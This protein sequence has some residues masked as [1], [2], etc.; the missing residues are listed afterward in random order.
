MNRHYPLF[1]GKLPLPHHP[2]VIVLM[3]LFLSLVLIERSDSQDKQIRLRLERW[4]EVSQLS[5][6]VTYQRG[7]TVTPARKGMRLHT[8]GDT[9]QTGDRSSATL[10]LDTEVGSITVSANTTVRIQQLQRLPNGGQWTRLVVQGGQARFQ[11]RRMTV[12]NSRFEVETPAGST[13]VRGTEFGVSV[14]PNGR[15]GVTTQEGSVLVNAQNQ[16]YILDAGYSM[17]LTL[18]APPLA[19]ART[20]NETH[21]RLGILVAVDERTARVTGRVNPLN[22]IKIA[23]VPQTTDA[24]GKFDLIL[25]LP[26]DRRLEAVVITPLGNQKRYELAVP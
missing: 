6:N 8:V 7:M 1:L 26:S 24:T 16:T 12:P 15:T 3:T 18:N 9:I 23:G 10:N 2:R 19:P 14:Q 17:L 13:A 20:A 4:L 22:L 11:V 5:G 25:P 21:L